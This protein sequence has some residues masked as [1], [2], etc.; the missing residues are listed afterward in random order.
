MLFTHHYW[1]D[2]HREQTARPSRSD[3]D[4]Q[5]H[6][7]KKRTL[8]EHITSIASCSCLDP[9]QPLDSDDDRPAVCDTPRED[10][11]RFD[12]VFQRYEDAVAASRRVR[13]STPHATITRAP[14]T[15]PPVITPM[16]SIMP[17]P[18]SEVET[19]SQR[20]KG[21]N[22]DPASPP[23]S[24]ARYP[25]IGRFTFTPGPVGAPVLGKPVKLNYSI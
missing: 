5:G 18:D 13:T 19:A 3:N 8:R 4:P 9:C 2:R 11:T 6:S 25:N 12:E 24:S 7:R 14:Y 17:T 20:T 16:S 15:T 1:K 10:S 21:L 23:L 22:M